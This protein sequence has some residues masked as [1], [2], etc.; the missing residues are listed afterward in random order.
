MYYT[1][2]SHRQ[3]LV[4]FSSMIRRKRSGGCQRNAACSYFE[5]SPKTHQRRYIRCTV[6]SWLSD[7]CGFRIGWCCSG[8]QTT[9]VMC[10]SGISSHSVWFT[11]MCMDVLPV[12]ACPWFMESNPT[13]LSGNVEH[14]NKRKIRLESFAR[15][16]RSRLEVAG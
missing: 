9:V 13:P 5:R 15:L 2:P 1:S 3:T 16:G 6:L 4:Y 11:F 12:I 10:C 14:L 8:Y 7:Y